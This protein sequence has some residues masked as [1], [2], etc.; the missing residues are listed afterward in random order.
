MD[1]CQLASLTRAAAVCGPLNETI[2]YAVLYSCTNPEQAELQI[3]S[4]LLWVGKMGIHK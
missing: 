2:S 4:I 1:I 3:K